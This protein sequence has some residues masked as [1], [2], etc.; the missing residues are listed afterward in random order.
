[1]STAAILIPAL[2]AA[3]LTLAHVAIATARRSPPAP[4]ESTP[5]GRLARHDATFPPDTL[6]DG[7]VRLLWLDFGVAGPGLPPYVWTLDGSAP[8]STLAWLGGMVRLVRREKALDSPGGG[9][10]YEGDDATF[11]IAVDAPSACRIR[12]V[13]GDPDRPRGPFDVS[14]PDGP[15]AGGVRTPAGQY[16]DLEFEADPV[17]GRIPIR[18]AGTGCGTFSVAAL[19]MYAPPGALLT[20]N[21]FDRATAPAAGDVAAGTPAADDS[22]AARR[23]LL[24]R[25]CEFLLDSR[26]NEG[27]FSMVGSWYQS[28]YA[29]RTLMAGG[30]LLREPAFA[31]AA[32]ECLDRFVAEQRPDGGWSATYFG[33]PGCP[34]AEAEIHDSA[35]ANLADGGSAALALAVAA[36]GVGPDRRERYVAAGRRYADAVVLPNQLDTGA[37]V[38]LKFMGVDHR[39]PYSVATGIQSAHLAALFAVTGETGYLAAAENGARFLLAGF[40]P[41]GRYGFHRHDQPGVV[42]I[43][44]VRFGDLYYIIEG[45]EWVRRYTGDAALAGSIEEA[46]AGYLW[47]PG[48]LAAS[49][50]NEVLWKAGNDWE[51]SK[52][53]ALL[54]LLADF[55][56]MSPP[57]AD[58]ASLDRRERRRRDTARWIDDFILWLERPENADQIGFLVDVASPGGVYAF[59]ATGF[60]GIGLAAAL[61]PEALFP[62]R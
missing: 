45:L 15:V 2:V 1:M 31:E 57:A 24:R 53:G 19:T 27:C 17:G 39:H 58:A 36:A 34:Q 8:N 11:A 61:D 29:I 55:H 35:S 50:T 38:N 22:L 60:T 28:A 18:I 13:L 6:A 59:P 12:L 47:G 40:L 42:P 44:S 56:R 3:A 48:G 52:Q 10:C 37:F 7:R 41:N 62:V 5:R 21:L 43:Q 23:R 25:A 9:D 16:R 14:L 54:A 46:L 30:Q 4:A 49:R 33:R 20:T 32:Y 51:A 26:P